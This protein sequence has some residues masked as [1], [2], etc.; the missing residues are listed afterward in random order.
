LYITKSHI[1]RP[2]FEPRPPRWETGDKPLELWRGPKNVLVIINLVPNSGDPKLVVGHL[3]K[4]F[5][6]HEQ[7]YKK[8]KQESTSYG[9]SVELQKLKKLD[10]PACSRVPQ[11]TTLPRAPTTITAT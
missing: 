6:F 1:T 11:P 4:A 3:W 5:E 8:V 9:C 2:E 10:L 7:H